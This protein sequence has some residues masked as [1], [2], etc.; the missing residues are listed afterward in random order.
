MSS[1]DKRIVEMQF[2]NSQF[3][4]GVR[5]SMRT[6]E[7]FEDSLQFKRA[8]K[9]FDSLQRAGNSFSLSR[10]ADGVDAVAEKFSALGI[11]GKR[12]LENLTDSAISMGMQF[13]K[14]LSVDNISAGFDK[15]ETKTKSVKTIMEATDKDIDYVN[16]RLDRLNWFTD[17]TSYNYSDMVSNIGKFTS[18]GV[19]LDDSVT[20]MQGIATWA[21]LSGQGVEQ[22]SHAMYNLS[23]AMAIGKVTS[24]DWRSIEGA[25]MATKEFKQAAIETAKAL[26]VLNKEGKTAKGTLVTYENFG[27]TLNEGWFTSDVLLK[28]LDQFGSAATQIYQ[29]ATEKGIPAAQAVRELG[30][31]MDDLGVRAFLAAQE[32]RTFKDAIDATK[33]AVST[34]WMKTFE[35]IFGDV[36]QATELFSEFTEILYEVFAAGGESRNELLAAWSKEEV[37]GRADLIQ[38]LLDL[39]WGLVAVINN[40]KEAFS[41][42]F[43]PFTIDTLKSISLYVKDLG[44]NFRACFEPVEILTGEFEE[45]TRTIPANPFEPFEKSF[46]RGAKGE[47]IKQLQERL[48]SLGYELPNFGADGI[49][50][51]ETQAALEAFQRDA[52]LTVNGIYDEATHHAIGEAMGFHDEDLTVIEQVEKK[53]EQLPPKAQKLKTFLQGIFSVFSIGVKVL[54]FFWGV[55]TRIGDTL[56]PIA[57]MFGKIGEAA[58]RFFI[59]LNDRLGKSEKFQNWLDSLSNTLGPIKEKIQA[60]CDQ[61]LNLLGIGGD[62]DE[63]DFNQVVENFLAGIKKFFGLSI[64]PKSI[65]DGIDAKSILETIKEKVLGIFESVK[66]WFAGLFSKK[67]G[68]PTSGSQILNFDKYNILI[69]GITVAIGLL[70]S[71]IIGMIHNFSQVGKNA[72]KLL[73]SIRSILND[74]FGPKESKLTE[75]SDAILKFAFA[76]GI[77]AASI[78][79]LSRLSWEQLA[80][81]VVGLAVILLGLVG[82]IFLFKKVS[83][84]FKDME[85]VMKAL[86][87]LAEAMNAMALVAVMLGQFSWEQLAKGLVGVIGLLGVAL[88]AIYVLNKNKVNTKEVGGTIG[89]I[90]TLAFALGNFAN[91]VKTLGSMDTKTLIQG[92]IGMVAV[93][94]AVGLFMKVADKMHIKWSTVA[95]LVAAAIAL[96]LVIAGF[97]VLAF[98][99][100]LLKPVDIIK[101]IIGMVAI[102]LVMAMLMA[103]IDGIKPSVRAILAL[104]PVAIALDLVI[105]GFIA[106]AFAMKAMTAADIVKAVVGLMIVMGAI[107]ALLAMTKVF[108]P[109]ISG[110]LALIPIAAALD[111]AIIGFVIMALA[112]KVVSWEDILKAIAGMIVVTGAITAMLAMTKLIKPSIRGILA[113][114]PIAL[115]MDLAIA[116]FVLLALAMRSISWDDLLKT[117]VAFGTIAVGM[118]ILS[119]SMTASTSLKGAIGMIVAMV[120]MAGAMVAFAVVLNYIKNVKTDKILAFA[121][122]L[123][124]IMLAFGGL[125]LMAKAAGLKGI[126]LAAVSIVAMTAAI[127][128]VIA[129]FAALNKIPGFQ[130]FMNSGAA[131]I[132]QI[133]G[134]FIEEIEAAKFKGMAKGMAALSSADYDID[135][136]KL[137]DMLETATA[138]SDFN[139]NLPDRPLVEKLIPWAKTNMDLTMSDMVSF[140]NG[141]TTFTDSMKL[142]N[143][144][145]YDAEKVKTAQ[146]IVSDFATFNENLPEESF[147]DRLVTWVTGQSNLENQLSDMESFAKGVGKFA[148][149]MPLVTEG[150]DGY[151]QTVMSQAMEIVKGFAD[152]NTNLP[153]VSAVDR[154]INWVSGQS[155]L[156]SQLSDMES[157]AKG[158][159]KFATYMPYVTKGLDGYDQ[160]T[161]DQA[162]EIVKGF[163]DFNTNLPQESA[164]DRI[165]SWIS[166]KSNLESQMSDM[167]S[168]AKGVGKFAEY[169]PLVTEGVSGYD[170]TTMDQAMEI[171]KGF[172]DFNTNLPAESTADRIITWITGK[173]NLESQLDD[174]E[175]FGKG[176]AKFAQQ[177]PEIAKAATGYDSESMQKSMDIVNGFATFNNNLPAVSFGD[178]VLKWLGV[179]STLDSTMDDMDT[180]AS[181]FNKFSES[182]A[183][184]TWTEDLETDTGNA[185]KIATDVATFLV[186]L[187]GLDI[188][189][190]KTGIDAWFSDETSQDTVFDAVGTLADSMIQNKDKFAGISEGTIVEDIKG[191][192]IAARVVASLLSYLNSDSF[193]SGNGVPNWDFQTILGMIEGLGSTVTTFSTT[194]EGIDLPAVS[195]A[196][197][198]VTDFLKLITEGPDN[199]SENGIMSF[200][201]EE[202]VAATLAGIITSI[203]TQF[204]DAGVDLATT[205]S[206]GMTTAE[207]TGGEDT[208]KKLLDAVNDYKDDFNVAGRNFAIGLGN[209]VANSTWIA[210]L[211]AQN[212]ATKMVNAARRVFNEHSPS[213]VAEQIGEY[214]TEGLAIGTTNKV[215]EATNAAA[216]VADSMLSTASGTLSTL[217]SLLADDID[218][219]PVIAPVVDL[220]NAKQS[221]AMIGGLFGNQSFGVTSQIMATRAMDSTAN[222]RPVTIQNGTLSTTESL[223]G[224]RD[225]L[226]ALASYLT[227]RND[228]PHTDEMQSLSERFGDLADAVSNLKIVL[229]TGTLVGQITPA[230][231]T[232]LG[233]LASRRDRG[234]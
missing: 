59:A 164:A 24:I 205:L 113:L 227:A 51:P 46:Q 71:G 58:S 122:G 217:S 9:S 168:F 21:A 30:L 42:I 55:L 53:I 174:L 185:I 216:D 161:M 163:A 201:S 109:S 159:C 117:I 89:L 65:G 103:L 125:S 78:W 108:K 181:G 177:M 98:A 222:G 41:E 210:V 169:M 60:L 188:E 114:V 74:K 178:R 44:A 144:D 43:P 16:E 182:M 165:I 110:I 49:F 39:L 96:D 152:F 15:Y 167:E 213:K 62:L 192:T 211:A 180:F 101:A 52:G 155:N 56:S 7:E 135:K 17:E 1:I 189:K 199:F 203:S 13:A 23:Q 25:S 212:A 123:S 141:I 162:M 204:N 75:I 77:L 26:G 69:A 120:A 48:M 80:K 112:M 157:F 72:S 191:A 22:A 147:A 138:F 66:N 63:I 10:M 76:T 215:G 102:V 84:G 5:Q 132:G 156:E 126:L 137:N 172:A 202:N 231:D 173:S 28:T 133:I 18:V 140:A 45:L 3:E 186:T 136:D 225:Q 149:Y 195:S 127:G 86:L 153:E 12:V 151:D 73:N 93:M 198:S 179:G 116:G 105:L 92:F 87:S 47:A 111:L 230:L 232:H 218:V 121:G 81:G 38:G 20:A 2:E 226:N 99:M 91:V 50:G 228:G 4:K 234:N 31:D 146:T 90:G 214:F 223:G 8:E 139:S 6:V 82:A 34:G 35:Y 184:I 197:T 119:A 134:T 187:N 88:L 224:V 124:A 68:D 104:L 83:K 160:A 171:V 85:S 11:I 94:V 143:T 183:G 193:N 220:T 57:K 175:G 206:N 208:A 176:M 70:G 32:A 194:V 54:K 154:I 33:D 209:G 118:A 36:E 207:L 150:L 128:L 200:L 166:G 95:G 97:L 148:T 233:S 19:D 158:V 107:T 79:L 40:V 219:N 61:F 130:D 229:D 131:S 115:A 196:I 221:A 106:L 37:G 190:K 29:Y 100:K 145:D 14:S 67:E 27:T 64:D 129:A 170:K 142:F